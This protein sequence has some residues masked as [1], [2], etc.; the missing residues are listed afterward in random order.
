MVR[1]LVEVVIIYPNAMF[2]Y[3]CC[4]VSGCIDLRRFDLRTV[5]NLRSFLDMAHL[6]M[7]IMDCDIYIYIYIYTYIS[8]IYIYHIYIYISY[9]I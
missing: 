3:L 9:A 4:C 2:S 5:R 1:S 7:P 6:G 8:Y